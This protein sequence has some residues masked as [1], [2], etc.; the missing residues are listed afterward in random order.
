MRTVHPQTFFLGLFLVFISFTGSTQ[1]DREMK[2]SE[3][4]YCE[5]IEVSFTN[6]MGVDSDVKELY[7]RCSVQDYF[8]KFCESKVTREELE[9]LV[10]TGIKVKMKIMDGNWDICP[11]DFQN[12]QSRVGRYAVIETLELS[13][14]IQGGQQGEVRE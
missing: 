13:G 8:I 3:Y 5:L 9:P 4:T 12:M 10:N 14:E 2:P 11:D 6:K 1:E 7:L